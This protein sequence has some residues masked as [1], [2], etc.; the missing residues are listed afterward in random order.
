VSVAIDLAKIEI[1]EILELSEMELVEE[2]QREV[3]GIPDLEIVPYSHLVAVREAGGVLIGAF[4][5]ALLVGFI[6]GFPSFE[7]GQLAHHSHMLG[8][9]PAYRNSDLGR[10]LKIAQRNYVM[11]QGIGLMSWT[12]DPLQCLNAHF[13][14]NKLG[15]VCDRYLVKFYGEHASSF[16]HQTGTDRLW[17]SW[18]LKSDRVNQKVNGTKGTQI[19]NSGIPLVQIEPDDS[20]RRNNLAECLALDHTSIEIPADIIALH[21]ENS[22]AALRWRDDTR[23][24]F[25]E[26]LKAGF[27]I[28]D[29]VRD[30]RIE[31]QLGRYIL[32]SDK[33]KPGF[34]L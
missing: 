4:D 12:F 1:R 25:T 20:S 27:V 11:A 6:Y 28:L 10:Q 32:S 22:E 21:R 13:N 5:Q 2:L 7:R 19:T 23:W 33:A 3:W 29:F 31:Q 24:A 34:L 14:F 16:L 15:V 18:L 17:I 9:K 8:V 30:T 26:A